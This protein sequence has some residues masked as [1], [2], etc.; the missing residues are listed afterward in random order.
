MGIPAFDEQPSYDPKSTILDTLN[1][2]YA[3]YL[4]ATLTYPYPY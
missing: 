2:P 3:Y 4:T 1:P